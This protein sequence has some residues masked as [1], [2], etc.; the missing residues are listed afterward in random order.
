MDAPHPVVVFACGEPL[1]GDDG[2]GPEAVRGLD[3]STRN[4]AVIR[5]VACLGPEELVELGPNSYVIIVDAV[6]GVPPG[7]LVRLDLTVLDGAAGGVAPTST[8]Q[9]PLPDVIG[10]AELLGWR[11]RGVF[12]GLGAASVEPG[13]QLSRSVAAALP[14]LRDSI[15]DAVAAASANDGRIPASTPEPGCFARSRR[16]S[17]SGGEPE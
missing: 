5:A 6:V 17:L 13:A 14:E 3:A 16:R 7:R 4:R 15:R 12:L 11:P 9:L 10:L 8:H 2:L 1:R